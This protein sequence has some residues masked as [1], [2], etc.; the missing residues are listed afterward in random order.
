MLVGCREG[1]EARARDEKKRHGYFSS[2]RSV[3]GWIRTCA[4]RPQWISSPSPLPLGH[5]YR[6]TGFPTRT[7]QAATSHPHKAPSRS[8]KE[9]TAERAKALEGTIIG[10]GS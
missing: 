3:V 8:L 2:E 6:S 7:K 5:D 10:T 9:I 4:G 1:G